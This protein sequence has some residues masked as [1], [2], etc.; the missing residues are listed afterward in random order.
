MSSPIVINLFGGPGA[1]KSTTAAGLFYEMKLMDIKC[2]LVTEYAK[3]LVYEERHLEDGILIFAQQQRRMKRLVGKV[4]YIITDSPLIMSEVY[5]L[6]LPESFHRLV[7]YTFNTFNNINVK[8]NRVKPYQSYGRTQTEERARALDLEINHIL[9]VP[10]LS[11]DGN[12]GAP[13]T[14]LDYL[15]RLKWLDKEK[16][17][18]NEKQSMEDTKKQI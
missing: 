3:E 17:S 6:A 4:D 8:I 18:T 9:G 16:G 1:G 15:L 14:I 13:K 11:V 7:R 10:D 5:Q 2:E 12:S